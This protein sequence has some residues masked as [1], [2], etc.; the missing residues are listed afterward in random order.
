MRIE[1]RRATGSDTHLRVR[2]LVSGGYP[3]VVTEQ[4]VFELLMGADFEV[5]AE[6]TGLERV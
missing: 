6:Q 4:I 3:I 5:I 2:G 1:F